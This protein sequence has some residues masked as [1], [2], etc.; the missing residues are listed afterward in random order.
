MQLDLWFDHGL[1]DCAYFAHILQLYKIRGYEFNLHCAPDKAIVFAPL[2][3]THVPVEHPNL[4]YVRYPESGDPDPACIDQYWLYNKPG[5]NIARPPL[6]DIGSPE[7]LWDELCSVKLNITPF[8]ASEKRRA[9][10]DFLGP[11]PRPVVLFHSM[12]NTFADAKNIPYDTTVEI[13]S[14][15]LDRMDGTLVLLDW[16]NRVP[17]L[18]NW[19]VRHM[20]D[21]W[22]WIDVET[23]LVLFQEADL[24]V[25]V[26]SGPLH[27]ARM[28]DI[29]TVGLFGSLN[30]YPC[31]VSCPG[32]ER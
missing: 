28:T 22:V 29:P 11:L 32:R 10:R 26:D 24:L 17:R 13:Y 27:L 15:I 1:G 20:T 12:G 7:E 3:P 4:Q 5:T 21:D 16:D 23:L 19:R 2:H 6:P 30:K 8:I 14:G 18:A 25:S 31:R 9:V